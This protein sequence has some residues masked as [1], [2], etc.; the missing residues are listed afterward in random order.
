MNFIISLIVIFSSEMAFS[1]EAIGFYSGGKL[2]DGVSILDS[3]INIHKLFLSR[4]RFFGTQEIQDVISDSAD[5]VRQ[6]YPQAE[7]IQI[8]DIA[9]KD[10][11]ICKGH[12]SHQNGLDADIV[13]LTKNGRLQSQDAPYWEEEFVKNNT[14]SS[15]FHVERNFSLFKFLIINKSVN[16]IF[17]DAAI[18]KEFCSFA[19]KNN[20][21]SD[22]ETVE[23]LR[24][25]RV[26]KLHSTHF[27][28]RINCPATD[29]TCKPQAEV[30]IG[31]GC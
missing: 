4:K 27:H 11:G 2:K 29:L 9:N 7:L 31:S 15:N 8:G 14:V 19:K 20:L 5:F 17:V 23:T 16:R 3:G 1:S 24:R 10:G 21:M 26:E 6:E 25:I 22:V 28:M 12:S 30:P 18:K 13:Y